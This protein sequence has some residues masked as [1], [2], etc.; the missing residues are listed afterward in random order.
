MKNH[1]IPK[2]IL[3]L[4]IVAC[5]IFNGG[6]QLNSK[7]DELEKVFMN[8]ENNDQLSIHYDLR[9]IDDSLS[10]FLSLSKLYDL[11]NNET[12]VSLNQLHNHFKENE[13]IEEYSQWY[14]QVKD[15][16][17][18]AIGLVKNEK[19]TDQHK[20]MLNR[21]E[22][23]FNSA[24]HTIAYSSFNSDVRDY[25]KETSGFISDLIKTLTGVKGVDT[26]D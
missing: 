24:I 20:T 9:K 13:T 2:I 12:I 22:A 7:V 8:G 19:L 23:T 15:L 10:Y 11:G 16:Y 4:V 26:F 21:Y 3:I 17:P 14:D 6:R 1:V 25:Q 5:G 18:V